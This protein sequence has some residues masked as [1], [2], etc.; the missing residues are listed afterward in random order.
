MWIAGISICL[1][2]VAG[3]VAIVSSIAPSYASIPVEDARSSNEHH[4][5]R[6]QAARNRRN[7]ARCPECGVV[8]AN[9]IGEN[10]YGLTIRFRDGST[11]VLEEDTQRSW[12][13][14]SRVIVIR[15]A[16]ASSR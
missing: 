10:G 13:T 15:G 8:E 2:V 6:A 1:L 12:Q 11:M 14:G 9:T 7:T 4:V 3:T 5:A 16:N